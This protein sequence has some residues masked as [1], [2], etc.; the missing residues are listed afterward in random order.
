MKKVVL[1]V[2]LLALTIAVFVQPAVETPAAQSHP[3][4]VWSILCY[5]ALVLLFAA[6]EARLIRGKKVKVKPKLA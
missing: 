2:I 5:L 1:F 6:V 3:V 4:P